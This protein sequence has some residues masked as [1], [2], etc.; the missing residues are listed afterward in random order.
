MAKANLEMVRAKVAAE[1]LKTVVDMNRTG[2][3]LELTRR[4]ASMQRA[5]TPRDQDPG[6]EARAA[7]AKAEA[8]MFQAELDY[9]MA[10]A[11]MKRVEGEQ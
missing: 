7:L 11:Q 5:L 10:Y 3:I 8:E 2:R 6:P 1:S 9:R 4:V